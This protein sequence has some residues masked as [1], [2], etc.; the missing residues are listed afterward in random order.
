MD[1]GGRSKRVEAATR[2]IYFRLWALDE[3]EVRP[4]NVAGRLQPD[5]M[6]FLR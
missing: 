6:I 1:G 2:E 4:A 5:S 3:E